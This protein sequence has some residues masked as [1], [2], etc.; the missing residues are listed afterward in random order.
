MRIQLLSD[1]H[2][3]HLPQGLDA[4]ALIR[5][6]A[7]AAP[8]VLAGD[9]HAGTRALEVF[10][11]WPVPVPYVLGNHEYYGHRWERLVDQTRQ[12]CA[13]SAVRLLERNRIDIDGVRFLGCTLWTDFQS[14][15]RPRMSS[16]QYAE[17]FLS[18]YAWIETEDSQSPN[19]KLRAEQTLQAHELARQ[20]LTRE[21]AVP[22]AGKTVVIIHHAAHRLST[23][24][25]HLGDPLTPALVSDLSDLMRTPS[26]WIHGHTHNSF[27]YAVGTC[28][29]VANPSGYVMKR[30]RGQETVAV[31]ENDQFDPEFTV[32]V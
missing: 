14:R 11:D 27:D 22:F 13:G 4:T 24:P 9:I 1:L 23:H 26:L 30:R 2:L 28:R 16:M 15:N 10:G 21:L 3:E 6:A 12:A 29:V 19:G 7:T 32:D 18:D 25:R 8:L 17:L 31:Q 20:W 5:R